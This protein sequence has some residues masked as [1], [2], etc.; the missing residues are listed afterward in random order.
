MGK[1]KKTT[2]GS[3]IRTIILFLLV[4]LTFFPLLLMINMSNRMS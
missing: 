3:V 4:F 1:K 2:I